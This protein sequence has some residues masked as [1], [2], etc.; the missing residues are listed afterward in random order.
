MPIYP[1][2]STGG[3]HRRRQGD[4]H[5]GLWPDVRLQLL[6]PARYVQRPEPRPI[7]DQAGWQAQLRRS[8]QV[9]D[10]Q[11][12][13]VRRGV[14]SPVAKSSLLR[15]VRLLSSLVFASVPGFFCCLVM[16]LF[17]QLFSLSF[18]S[19]LY[20]MRNDLPKPYI[21]LLE[22]E[23]IHAIDS[24]SDQANSDFP[25]SGASFPSHSHFPHFPSNSL[26]HAT[27]LPFLKIWYPSR[28]CLALLSR[29]IRSA[30][31]SSRVRGVCF[32][33]A[34]VNAVGWKVKGKGSNQESQSQ[35]M[36]TKD[37]RKSKVVVVVVRTH[38]DPS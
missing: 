26:A 35:K 17:V 2:R 12:Q 11:D 9:A 31:S 4:R 28:S 24:R 18:S 14:L 10:R 3:G 21:S 25:P 22:A 13:A 32:I 37:N 38:V 34:S 23:L 20:A 30:W 15:C 33:S 36:K 8:E 29:L 6:C 5:Q 27:P 1:S 19:F 16:P 7:L